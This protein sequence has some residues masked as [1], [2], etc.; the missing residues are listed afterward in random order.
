VISGFSA[1]WFC[2]LQPVSTDSHF[3]HLIRVTSKDSEDSI[4]Y[5]TFRT[6]HP[7]LRTC[8][9]HNYPNN[10]FTIKNCFHN[11][12]THR[13]LIWGGKGGKR[14]MFSGTKNTPIFFLQNI[15]LTF[16][17]FSL[18]ISL[19]PGWTLILYTVYPAWL[20]HTLEVQTT[21]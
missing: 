20:C 2:D 5:I 17:P 13:L 9:G 7:V 19:T 1:Y 8:E 18:P 16:I 6:P 21:G 10:V 15:S 11:C 14:R 12:F 3:L 4:L